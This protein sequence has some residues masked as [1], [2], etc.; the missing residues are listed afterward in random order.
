MQINFDKDLKVDNTANINLY[1]KQLKIIFNDEFRKKI[2]DA[3]LRVEASYAK[4]DDEKYVKELSKKPYEEQQK[5]A[6]DLMKKNKEIVISTVDSL[7]G[8]GIGDFLYQHFNGSTE[9][10]SA[11]LGLLEEYAD[12]A[13]K[14]IK[15]EKKN[16]K[17]AKFK[18]HH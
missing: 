6:N 3:R 12:D 16:K 13:V 15:R 1:G 8:N 5:V 18:N 10:V 2:A 17:L 4:L 14:N 9:A 11:V 7:L